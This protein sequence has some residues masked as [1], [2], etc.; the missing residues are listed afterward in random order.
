MARPFASAPTGRRARISTYFLW[1]F[2]LLFVALFCIGL[3]SW[4]HVFYER[5]SDGRIMGKDASQ[6]TAEFGKPVFDST[7][8]NNGAPPE[9][10]D[11]FRFI[12]F[13]GS[14]NIGIEFVK[15]KATRVDRDWK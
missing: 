5:F 6:I 12:Y 1:A 11:K 4:R 7:R 3:Q 8:L 10:P 2:A 14:E 9:G 13:D 15:G